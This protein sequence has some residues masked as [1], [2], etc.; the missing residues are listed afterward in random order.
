MVSSI[1]SVASSLFQSYQEMQASSEVF[2]TNQAQSFDELVGNG[3]VS[4]DG[5]SSGSGITAMGGGEKSESKDKQYSEMDLN[6]DG[7]VT[8]DE[9]VKYM[10]MQNS[11]KMSEQMSSEDGSN[12]MNQQS[13]KATSIDDYKNQQ[14]SKAYA[15]SQAVMESVT[16]MISMS[17]AV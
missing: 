10:Q 5:E 16:D 12:E 13:Q 2:S 4:V 8:I 11:E 14:A 6:K 1:G 15:S 3:K 7:Q 9:V 17:F